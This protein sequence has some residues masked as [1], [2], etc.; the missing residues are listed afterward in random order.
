MRTPLPRAV[1]VAVVLLTASAC[2]LSSDGPEPASTPSTP[3]TAPATPSA[4]PSG[5]AS[6]SPTLPTGTGAALPGDIRTRPTVVAAI[7]DTASRKDVA[8]DEVVVAAW[9]PVTW[10]DGSLGCPQKGMSYTQAMVEGELLIL[11]VD[12]ALFQYHARSGGP[13]TYCATPSAEYSVGG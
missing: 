12:G 11:R 7:E 4:T 9:S 13:F 3:S 8:P 1:V 2:A 6:P 5:T 10:T